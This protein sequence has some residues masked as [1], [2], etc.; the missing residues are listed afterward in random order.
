MQCLE[1]SILLSIPLSA[2]ITMP[3][4]GLLTGYGTIVFGKEYA[5]IP[6]G[7]GDVVRRALREFAEMALAMW[8]TVLFVSF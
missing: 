2:F 6:R 7:T 5:E 3:I 4:V 8:C 1:A